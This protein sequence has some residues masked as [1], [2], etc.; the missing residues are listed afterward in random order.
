[1]FCSPLAASGTLTC[2]FCW[3]LGLMTQVG[4]RTADGFP[5][6]QD[7]FA[8][9]FHWSG[10]GCVVHRC[11]HW[12][13]K[14]KNVIYFS[15]ETHITLAAIKRLMGGMLS[16]DSIKYLK[17]TLAFFFNVSSHS[18]VPIFLH[19]VLGRWIYLLVEMFG[20]VTFWEV[21]YKM[22]VLVVT[23]GLVTGFNRSGILDFLLLLCFGVVQKA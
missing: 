9:A 14:C 8:V 3:G 17:F 7:A 2:G 22:P 10:S 4:K 13:G 19:L 23:G 11:C 20:L 21:P 6:S 18:W 15:H 1:M 12:F 16:M 5:L